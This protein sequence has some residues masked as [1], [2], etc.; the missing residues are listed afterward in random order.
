MFSRE[1][2]PQGVL[3][4]SPY[5]MRVSPH[6]GEIRRDWHQWFLS[7][8]RFPTAER[9][10]QVVAADYP[11]L[12]AAA[13]PVCDRRRLW[14]ITTIIALDIEGDDDF[15]ANRPGFGDADRRRALLSGLAVG[16]D[17]GFAERAAQAEPR[18]GPLFADVWKSLSAYVPPPLL[19]R[20]AEDH[21]RYLE[22]CARVDDHLAAH[23]EFTDIDD[24]MAIRYYSLGQRMDHRYTEISL[25]IDLSDVIEEPP[26]K[27]VVDSDMRRTTISQDVLSLYK[28][29]G[30][31]GDQTENIVTLIARTRRCALPA[32]LATASDMFAAEVRNF[33]R[34]TERLAR[35][36]LGRRPDVTAFVH[37]LNDFCAGYMDW[38]TGSGR[39]TL[40]DTCPW[41]D[42]PDVT[43]DPAQGRLPR[44]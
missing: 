10:R 19:R 22:G 23:G 15:D 32:A 18:W 3:L 39:Y 26:L 2:V 31:G 40:R 11:R 12:G 29:L 33:D 14:D 6:Y 34:L 9:Q 13:W 27:A 20:L 36:S 44:G 41:W 1:E 38:T 25:G 7:T 5:P 30:P 8:E 35:T 24:Y 16:F 43:A 37:G 17:S 42:T 28:D 4:R 21:L